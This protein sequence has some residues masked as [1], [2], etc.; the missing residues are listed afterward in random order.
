MKRKN[1]WNNYDLCY[2]E[3]QKYNSRYSFELG[4]C[5][6]YNHAL[7]N[8]WLDDYVWFK[9]NYW[10]E[11]D[12]KKE[13]M[14]YEYLSDFI[15]KSNGAYIAALKHNWIGQYD[16]LKRNRKPRNYWTYETCY[17][18]AKEYT[19]LTDF[20]KNHP[21]AY[22]KILKNKWMDDLYWL[23]DDRVDIIT[24]KIDLVYAYEFIK[25]KSVYVGRTL[26]RRKK[27]RDKE[28][29]FEEDDAVCSFAKANNIS[30]P[31]MKILESDLTIKESTKK[32]AFY[33]D[34]YKNDGWN[35]LNKAKA[36]SV[37]TIGKGNWTKSKCY[38]E[39]LKYKT[40]QEFRKNSF[41]AYEYARKNDLLKLY[42][43]L[44]NKRTRKRDSIYTFEICYSLAKEC[45]YIADF[46]KKNPQAYRIS[47]RNKWL[48]KFT[49][50][51]NGRYVRWENDKI[52]TYESCYNEAKKYEYYLDYF[53][54]S[55]GS[56]RVAY[57]NGWINDYVWLKR[58]R[59]KRGFWNHETCYNEAKKYD[60]LIDFRYK[61]SRAYYVSMNNG[62]INEFN[63]LKRQKKYD[64]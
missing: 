29:I 38:K 58:N 4:C 45:S 24:G 26:M 14:K 16:F 63:W 17:N 31:E 39:A 33:I 48:E 57:K 6:A 20:A 30:V 21:S 10:T 18:T 28:H 42:D 62:W 36:G 54:N 19:N 5:S 23:K 12:C 40:Q 46:E 47:K 7:K 35:I 53:N 34:K 25:L 64:S 60:K 3:A 15:N 41:R 13:A 59:R 56:Y 55:N 44:D 51:K 27:A 49:W 43:W 50:F 37:G 11:E 9:K 52:H 8:H 2:K 1:Y 61:S 22:H 32:E